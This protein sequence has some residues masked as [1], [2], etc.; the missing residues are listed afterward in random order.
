MIRIIMCL[1]IFLLFTSASDAISISSGSAAP[2]FTSISVDGK[3][4]SLNDYKGK[5]LVIIFWRTDQERSILALQDAK[6]ILD[7][8]KSKGIEVVSIM[9]ES[10]NKEE[11][12]MIFKNKE[13]A[14]P[15]LIDTDRKIYSDYG[16]RVFPTT[17]IMDIQGLVAYDIPSHPLTYKTKLRGYIK[18]IL[19]EINES[20]LEETL[21]P[22][23]EEKDK[24]SM[25]AS[26]LYNLALKFT[27]S[28]IFDTAIDMAVKSVN[29]SP[30]M[31]ESRILLGFL[32][33][34]TKEADK[35][36]EAF[37][38]AVELDPNSHDAKTGLGGALILKGDIDKALEVLNSAAVAN[39]Y[40][41]MT[42][43]ELGKA[44]ELRGDKARSSEMY[45]KAIEKLIDKKILPASISKC[46]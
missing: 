23:R 15:L 34:E 21:S 4:I 43:F 42:Y 17:V 31:V 11:A 37:N 28:R 1:V 12:L 18:K 36:L 33:L 16:V 45:K 30:E 10:D 26:R 6:E 35:A 5:V 39:P 9:E 46:E 24:A 14:F 3:R 40:P 13:I 25:E 44:Y 20:E 2:D 22:H 7:K 41:Q 27:E 38:K 8:Y 29:A 32:Y 19:G